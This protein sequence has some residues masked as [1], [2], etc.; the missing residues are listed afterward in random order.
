MGV[1]IKDIIEPERITFKDLEGRTIAIDA[2]NTLYQFLAIIR[3]RDGTPLL[4]R[5]GNV[6]SHLSGILYRNASIIEKGIKP[7]YVFDG[8]AP[9]EKSETQEARRQVR[10]EADAKWKE[11]LKVGDEAT[12]RKYA[13][14]STKM[15]PYII[16]SAKELLTLMGIPYIEA[17]GE[18]EAQA[19]YMVRKGDAWAVGSQDYDC[20]LFG[21]R[22]V[23]RNLTNSSKKSLE[24]YDLKKVLNQLNITQEELVDMGLLIGTD[25]NDGIKGISS[26]KALKLASKGQLEEKIKELPDDVDNLR[27]I[28]L[29]HQVNTDYKIKWNKVD[30]DKIYEFM[31]EQHG[32]SP[33]RLENS[34][35]KLK[36]LNTGQKSLEAW[37]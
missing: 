13:M 25:F 28:F 4:D 20:L 6:T 34:I 15:S 29:N 35:K 7:I 26:K 3:Q 22:R 5:E 31:C 9:Q 19:T 12:A 14:R 30:Y 17:Y 24:F 37:F 23:I 33:E 27:N 18:G 36:T 16:E 10:A 32:F 1:K 11:A 21:A 2:F 8:Q